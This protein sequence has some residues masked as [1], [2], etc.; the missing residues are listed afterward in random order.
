MGWG[1]ACLPV[2]NPCFRDPLGRPV[3]LPSRLLYGLPGRQGASQIAGKHPFGADRQF[4]SHNPLGH[5]AGPHAGRTICDPRTS[6]GR[7]Y[8]LRIRWLL[9]ECGMVGHRCVLTLPGMLQ[10]WLE[11]LHRVEC[12]SRRGNSIPSPAPVSPDWNVN[13]P[14]S[15]Q[16]LA[17]RQ[18]AC[19]PKSPPRVPF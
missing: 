5:P 15:F 1:S 3:R 7:L 10:N 18:R 2:A 6:C 14:H 19:A 16:W 17:S 9:L 11:R 12:W 13:F 8:V 4:L